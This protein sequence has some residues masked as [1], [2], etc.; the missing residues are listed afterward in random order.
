MVVS[1]WCDWEVLEPLRVGPS[2]KNST[3]GREG[4]L[5]HK[6]LFCLTLGFVDRLCHEFPPRQMVL[7]QAQSEP[8]RM[9]G[10]KALRS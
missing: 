8:D 3:E 2:W 1:L 5:V 6:S 4:E 10:W 7:P 9:C